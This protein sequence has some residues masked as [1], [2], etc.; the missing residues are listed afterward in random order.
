MGTYFIQ[1]VTVMGNNNHRIFK[2]DEEFLQ[3]GDGIQIQMVGRLIQKQDVR[4][5]E[6]RFGKEYLHLLAAV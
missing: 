4:V 3:P 5:A 2:I 6:K 1:E